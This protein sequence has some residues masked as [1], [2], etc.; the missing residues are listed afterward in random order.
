MHLRL[1]CKQVD[2][3]ITSLLCSRHQFFEVEVPEVSAYSDL[4]LIGSFIN[5]P[6]WSGTLIGVIK[7][8]TCLVRRARSKESVDHAISDQELRETAEN[9]RQRLIKLGQATFLNDGTWSVS[10]VITSEH[11]PRNVFLQ[12]DTIEKLLCMGKPWLKRWGL[13]IRIEASAANN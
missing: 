1:S 8:S 12:P 9:A 4:R 11:A 2:A 5:R 3:E 7:Y 6:P 10:A 13:E